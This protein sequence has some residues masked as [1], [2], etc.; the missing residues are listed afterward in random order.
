MLITFKQTKRKHPI[1]IKIFSVIHSTCHCLRVVFLN[2]NSYL[3]TIFLQVGSL[4][5]RAQRLLQSPTHAHYTE[6]VLSLQSVR[7]CQSYR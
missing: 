6:Q 7:S 1:C 4:H 5:A 3:C 2:Y